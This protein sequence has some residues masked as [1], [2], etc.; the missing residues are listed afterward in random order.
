M[1]KLEAVKKKRERKL[2]ELKIKKYKSKNKR[3]LGRG[4]QADRC[5]KELREVNDMAGGDVLKKFF[6]SCSS[7]VLTAKKITILKIGSHKN[8]QTSSPKS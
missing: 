3:D 7:I 5:S 6:L 1:T 8:F 4:G 2:G